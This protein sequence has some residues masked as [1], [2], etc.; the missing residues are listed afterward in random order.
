M[1]QPNGGLFNPKY[2]AILEEEKSMLCFG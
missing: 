2:V 1:Y